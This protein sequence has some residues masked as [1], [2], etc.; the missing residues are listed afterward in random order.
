MV[1]I[2]LDWSVRHLI[3]PSNYINELLV[4]EGRITFDFASLPLYAS[5]F[6]RQRMIDGLEYSTCVLTYIDK[7]PL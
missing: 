5:Y 1:Q 3:L 4:K 2:G 6:V 7:L